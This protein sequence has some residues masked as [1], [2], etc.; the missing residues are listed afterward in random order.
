MDIAITRMD[1][2]MAIIPIDTIDPIGTTVTTGVH[3]IE[4]TDTIDTTIEIITTIGTK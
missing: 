4:R 2:T 3:I 1:T